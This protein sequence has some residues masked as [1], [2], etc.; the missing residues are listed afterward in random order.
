[1]N[2]LRL[3]IVQGE[4]LLPG[5]GKK[6]SGMAPHGLA[7]IRLITKFSQLLIEGG[8]CGFALFQQIVDE[9]LF[10]SLQRLFI[11]EDFLDIVGSPPF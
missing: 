4:G 2:F 6:I 5:F 10:A 11:R 7:G 1:V 3:R 9:G 8:D